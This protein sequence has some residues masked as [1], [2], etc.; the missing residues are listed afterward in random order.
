MG[1]SH[2]TAS[3]GTGNGGAGGSG[4]GGS[5]ARDGDS[6]EDVFTASLTYPPANGGKTH[7]HMLY[8]SH[9]L[10]TTRVSIRLC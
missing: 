4:A 3:G 2:S 8:G 9:T 7:T 6:G 10:L 5:G 1:G